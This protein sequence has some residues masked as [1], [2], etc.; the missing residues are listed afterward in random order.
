MEFKYSDHLGF[1]NQYFIK[2]NG[3]IHTGNSFDEIIMAY[4]SP[5]EIDLLAVSEILNNNYIF[6]DRTIVQGINKSP[7]M[8]NLNAD[9]TDWNYH[10]VPSHQELNIDENEIA[11]ELFKRLLDE[12]FSYTEEKNKIGVL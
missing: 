5:I 12:I 10:D 6:G 9:A 2:R 11:E 8:A 1:F 3:L 7:W 4:K